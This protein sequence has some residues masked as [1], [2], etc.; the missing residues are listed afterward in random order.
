MA[1]RIAKP[2]P[3]ASSATW[4][5]AQF[6]QMVVDRARALGW[7]VMH[8]YR[9]RGR[10]GTWLT[11]TSSKGYPDLTLVRRGRLMFVELKA[12]RGEMSPEQVEWLTDLQTV[13]G[14]VEAYV[15]RPS[16][17]GALFRRL[18]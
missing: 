9:A 10:Q 16:Q 5:E 1:R 17:V 12:E 7:K 6:Q 14:T 18:E 2:D 13:G 4:S 11:N 3:T 8:V 15:V